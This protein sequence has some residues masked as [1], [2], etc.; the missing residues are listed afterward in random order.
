VGN[1]ALTIE[2]QRTDAITG[3]TPEF[4]LVVAD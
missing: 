1:C 3:C 2:H 4:V